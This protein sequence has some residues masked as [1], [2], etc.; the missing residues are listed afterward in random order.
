MKDTVLKSATALI[1]V[2]ILCITASVVVG[3]YSDAVKDA[4][5][6]GG[7]TSAVGGT[8]DDG[9][10]QVTPDDSSDLTSDETP[11]VT[12]ATSPADDTQASTSASGETATVS[13]SQDGKN[14]PTAYSKEQ[15]VE[16]YTESMTKSYNAQKVTI[17]KTETIAISVDSMT[18]GGKGA[19]ALANKI[20]E[21]Y[22]KTTESTKAFSK[23]VATDDGAY[24]ANDYGFPVTLDPKGAKTATVTKKGNNYEINIQVVSESATLEK[25]PVYNKQ[26]SFPLDLGAVDLFGLTI[27]QA[28]FSYTGTKLKATVGADGYV[29]QAEVYMPLAGKGGGKFIGISGAAEVSGSM[30]RT[31]TFTY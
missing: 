13:D 28:D 24:K 23:G 15:V 17:K 21:A 18:P 27:T 5:K 7:E 16:Y 10:I 14:D 25:F 11:D 3:N 20:V 4:A 29:R 22:A 2:V 26:C 30:K 8:V 19:A 6:L 31:L 9:N 1:C 12:D